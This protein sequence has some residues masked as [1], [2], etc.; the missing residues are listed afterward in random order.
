M[1]EIFKTLNESY[2][3]IEKINSLEGIIN[4]SKKYP[5]NG[6]SAKIE[7]SKNYYNFNISLNEA[8][9]RSNEISYNSLG[10]NNDFEIKTPFNEE[11]I[12]P[13]NEDS[14][15][16]GGITNMT[17]KRFASTENVKGKL[18][19]FHSKNFALE[20][21]TYLRFFIPIGEDSF[22][23]KI[24]G[25]AYKCD[26]TSY[27]YGLVKVAIFKHLIEIY[28]HENNGIKYLII[29]SFDKVSFKD[30]KKTCYSVMKILG[31][32]SGNWY[33]SECYFLSYKNANMINFS[34]LFFQ[35][36]K[37]TIES[38]LK[39]IDPFH[40][41]IYKREVDNKE[42]DYLKS[43]FPIQVFQ[44]LIEKTC[45]N[46]A[47][48]RATESLLE[49]LKNNSVFIRYNVYYV[50]IETLSNIFYKGVSKKPIKNTMA[51]DN[52]SDNV[53]NLL[54]DY[55]EDFDEKEKEFI[56]KKIQHINNP[57]NA[58]KVINLFSGF[59]IKMSP[60]YH[61]LIKNRNLF[62]HGKTSIKKE[63]EIK[64]NIANLNEDA[65]RV[66]LLCCI[67]ILKGTGYVG[68]IKNI[69]GEMN[70]QYNMNVR[71]ENRIEE[72]LYFNI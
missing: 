5:I 54:N 1:K 59:Q 70:Y 49:G 48:S 34:G 57:F 37:E 11:Y 32:L 2:Q 10:F 4:C 30:F 6:A 61:K 52:F 18:I 27:S 15:E 17:T 67:L 62:L 46:E 21:P 8:I 3:E 40:Y 7:K 39:L 45:S 36:L 66:Y 65:S 51:L 42:I 58:D 47:F 35:S 24:E 16:N 38:G 69:T 23:T 20:K 25:Q 28:R 41:R 72:P 53:K 68:H 13:Y 22:I 56:L 26:D 50:V 55:N 60:R 12:I 9:F 14:Y 33:R 64:S 31:I 29:E 19:S 71:G 43:I 44:T 63:E